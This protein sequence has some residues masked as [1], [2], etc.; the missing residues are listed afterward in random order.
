RVT[1]VSKKF[2]EEADQTEKW[3]GTK[4]KVEKFTQA[5]IRKWSNCCLHKNLRLPDKNEFI[6]TNFDLLPKDTEALSLP[7]IVKNSEFCRLWHKQDD[8]FLKPK[9]CVNIDF[10]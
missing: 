8:K 7:D 5:Q 3:Y 6:P 4:Y 2:A 10:M 9:A 1:I